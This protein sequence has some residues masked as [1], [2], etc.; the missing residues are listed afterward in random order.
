MARDEL[1]GWLGS[2]ARY[3]GK[4]GGSDLPNWLEI[5]TAGT[6]MVDRKTGDRPA[7]F[8]KRAAA[9]VVGGIQPG[10]MV[11]SLTP[12]FLAAGLGARLLMAMPPKILKRWTEIEVEADIEAAYHATL[13]GLLALEFDTRSGEQVPHALKLSPEGKVAWVKFYNEWAGEQ[14]AVEGELA[15]AFS[16][17]EGYAARFA[18]LHHVIE[19]VARDDDDLVPIGPESIAA[20]VTL[21][22]WCAQEARRIYS[23]LTESDEECDTR[24]LVEFIQGRG[25]SIS[26]RELQRSNNR[27]YPDKVCA[28]A[29]LEALVVAGLGTWRERAT[30]KGGNPA[31]IFDLCTTH[32]SCDT[33]PDDDD[34]HAGD[35]EDG[36]HDSP[37]NRTTVDSPSAT[38]VNDA[39]ASNDRAYVSARPEDGEQ[40]SQV[41]CCHAES[42][43]PEDTEPQTTSRGGEAQGSTVVQPGQNEVRDGREP[44]YQLV[45]DQAGLH[46]LS[47]A[48]TGVALVAV[49]TE[50]TGLDH[51]TDQVRLLSLAT[52]KGTY[53]I[54]LFAISDP[55]SLAPVFGALSQVE[56]IGHNLGFDLP[57]LIRLGFTPGRVGDTILASQLLHA[58][59]ITTKHGLKDVAAR[60]LGL[61]LDKDLQLA[62]W[63]GPLTPEM[64]RYAALDAEVPVRIWEKLTAEAATADMT[65]VLDIESAALPCIAWASVKGV[66]FDRQAWEALA[67]QAEAE[68]GRLREELDTQAP[69]SGS[70]F[71]TR[72]WD[73]PGDVKAA[74]AAL[75]LNL[76]STDDDALAEVDHPLAAVVR[77][78]RSV[79]RL[80]TTYGR[81]WL[82]HVAPNDRVYATW[83]QIG[84]GASGRMSCKEPNLQQLPRDPRYRRCFVAPPGR[85]LMKADYS[86]IELRIA[87][88]ITG[89]RRM[90]DAYRRG[91][92]LHTL[93]AQALLGKTEVAKA[94]RQ[95]AKAVNFGLLYGQ[96]AEGLRRY[97]LGSFGVSLT[98]AE[99]TAHRETFFR[100]YPGLRAWHRKAGREPVET[101]TLAGRRR[102]GVARYTEK[103]N[104]PVQGTGADGL[105]RALALLWQRRSACPDAFPVLFVHDEIVVECPLGQEEEAAI[106]VRDAMRDGMAP[107]IDPIPVEVEVSCGPTWGG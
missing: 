65:G 83:K 20:G 106:W 21:C 59:E 9:S 75:G 64:P 26:I 32:D 34:D 86:Q 67:G 41:S 45:T 44:T 23:T 72:N 103:L 50:T 77:D 81:E 99:A 53:L 24:R 48:L 12:E 1:A 57:F 47:V 3:K 82:R 100:T 16:K 19:R 71:D 58:G 17:L 10:V 29:A 18:L 7:L 35:G 49:D 88:K 93:T 79:A 8:V 37:P 36:M 11:R 80:A 38:A 101:R 13:D 95:L 25:G 43:E 85:S 89:D 27:K 15:A 76:E 104:T 69:N 61:I 63:S 4:S 14:S 73:S 31:Q 90:L 22:R 87:A 74:F 2:F 97:A 102:V 92:D 55:A 62:N 94:D 6:I 51:A 68:R 30:P 98:L 33:C 42:P 96:G 70:L 52:P 56:V 39:N 107:L 60:V 5:S 54:D 91:E 66:G 40:V 84:A 105:N 46:E 78:Y 28:E